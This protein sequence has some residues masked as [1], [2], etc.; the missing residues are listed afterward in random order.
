VN[1]RAIPRGAVDSYLRLVRFPLDGV[2]GLLPGNGTGAK[3]AAEL[4]LD[5]LDAR[6]R[7]ALARVL[8]DPILRED[9]A[10]RHSAADHR[11]RALRL[12][13]EA[14]RK[15]EAADTRLE[16]RQEQATHQREQATQGA[17]ARRQQATREQEEE[18]RRAA[19][20]ESDRLKTSRRIAELGEEAVN[21]R[22]REEQL[23]T[24]NA[25]TDALRDKEKEL[26]VRDEARRLRDTASRTKT[27]RK[28]S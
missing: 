18:E 22:A 25:R 9:A 8:S 27:D 11:E 7:A 15:A 6:L 28:S 24:V 2:I 5:R 23:K 19:Q 20:T 26:A 3:P 1:I 14:E 17:A 10:Q 4:A 21:Q 12:R 13:A 16:E